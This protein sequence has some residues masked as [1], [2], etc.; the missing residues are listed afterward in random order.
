M[1]TGEGKLIHLDI[2][3]LIRNYR[4]VVKM[5]ND[6]LE[7]RTGLLRYAQNQGYT[8]SI[9]QREQDLLEKQYLRVVQKLGEWSGDHEDEIAELLLKLPD[10]LCYTKLGM[11]FT[12]TIS[13][14]NQINYL[15]K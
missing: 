4:F 6:E 2:L 9:C 15:L 10:S 13:I 11:K 14:L 8:Y 5:Y 7:K 12:E 3:R 1:T